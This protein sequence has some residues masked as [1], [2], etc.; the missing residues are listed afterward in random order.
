MKKAV[1][2]LSGGLDTTTVLAI[3]AKE[4]DEVY[5][6]SFD[7]GQRNILELE[8]AKSN[9]KKYKNVKEHLIFKIDLGQIG[10]SALTDNIDVP[11]D[12]SSN[13]GIPI[14]YVPARNTIFN[15]I[16]LGYAEKV[17]ANFIYNGVNNMD[18]SGYPDCRPEYMESFQK[19]ANLATSYADS[20]QTLTYITP[21]I[22][23]KKS[24]IIK[25]GLE[26][27]VD[28]ADSLSCY[29]PDTQGRACGHCDACTF[30]LE[31]FAANKITDPAKYAA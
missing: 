21:L 17:R 26:L 27:G 1:I 30:R 14:T 28:Y 20:E 22:N 23:L 13:P 11:K 18:Y 19:M 4:M 5:C 29:D 9:A 25:I 15:S 6:I 16:A 2:Q 12:E 31:G 24:E 7:Y 10:G 3:A 8:C